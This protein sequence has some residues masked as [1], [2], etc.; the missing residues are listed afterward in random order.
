[1]FINLVSVPVAMI[2]SQFPV[3]P[4]NQLLN[5]TDKIDVLLAKTGARYWMRSVVLVWKKN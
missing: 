3:S 2:T 1:M 4:N 5:L